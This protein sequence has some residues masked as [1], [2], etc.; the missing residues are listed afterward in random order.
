[1]GYFEKIV[2]IVFLEILDNLEKVDK[3]GIS[4]FYDDKYILHSFN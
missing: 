2:N 3:L 4:I 1:M